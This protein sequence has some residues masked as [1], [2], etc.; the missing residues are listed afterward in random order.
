MVAFEVYLKVL[1]LSLILSASGSIFEEQLGQNE[2][3][4]WQCHGQLFTLGQEM[5]SMKSLL[6]MQQS[7]NSQQ[8][9]QY[10]NQISQLQ[11]NHQK[12]EAGC[13]NKV[14]QLQAELK[15]LKSQQQEREKL[16]CEC[17]QYNTLKDPRRAVTNIANWKTRKTDRL[18]SSGKRMS[19]T[20]P[21][22]KGEGWYRF[23]G[24]FTRMP[25]TGEVKNQYRCGTE[26]PVWVWKGAHAGIKIGG[27][28]KLYP[29]S[30]AGRNA[31]KEKIIIKRCPGNFF[32]YRLPPV[33]DSYIG[34]CGI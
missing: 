1:F 23:T 26:N 2:Q 27:H 34:Y 31:Q 30:L 7:Q 4:D 6:A 21:D 16:P 25:E 19:V 20:A 15:T 11:T 29:N 24:P 14:N 12:M 9:A 22:W 17:W 32:V 13:Q 28:L 18:S 3:N 8:K 33:W 10:Q 5:A